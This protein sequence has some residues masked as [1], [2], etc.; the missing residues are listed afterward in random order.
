MM[1]VVCGIAVAITA[2]ACEKKDAPAASG[3]L[4]SAESELLSRVPAG[5]HLVW[6][7]SYA[8]LQDFMQRSALGR[9][10]REAAEEMGGKGMAAWMQCISNMQSLRF[11]GGIRFG[12]AGTE[13][14]MVTSGAGIDDFR[15]CATKAGLTAAVD[16][17]GKFLRV[18]LPGPS[19]PIAQGYLVVADRV[20]YMRGA[21]HFGA[22]MTITSAP[23]AELE[24]DIAGLREHSAATDPGT[25]ALLAKVDRSKTAW[26]A[27][28]ATPV[29]KGLGEVYGSL[30]VDNGV[31]VD[32]VVQFTDQQLQTQIEDNLDQVKKH[33]DQAPSKA[34]KQLVDNL[35]ARRVGD[36][37]RFSL[38]ATDEQLDAL[39]QMSGGMFGGM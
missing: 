5:N 31:A 6:G 4:S 33:A 11:A 19:E 14:R 7:G 36:R 35:S 17:D 2:G 9:A 26:F 3:A 34:M 25:S 37:T 30:D 15:G 22:G 27:G 8:K 1:R 10:S 28:S 39:M 32:V 24:A 18:E 12:D 20:L 38:K 13:M 21:I 16:P 29:A 23:R